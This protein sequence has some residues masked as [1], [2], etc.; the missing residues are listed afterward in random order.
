V[1]G[2]GFS[3]L[4]FWI[5]NTRRLTTNA[6]PRQRFRRDREKVR[7]ARVDKA[8]GVRNL[9]N[10]EAWRLASCRSGYGFHDLPERA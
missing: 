9:R 8:Q 6:D 5:A 1:N 4:E 10:F 2:I 7:R 3:S